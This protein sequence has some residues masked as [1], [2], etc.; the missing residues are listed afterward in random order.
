[1]RKHLRR[2]EGLTLDFGL[3][4]GGH[5]ASTALGDLETLLACLKPG[6]YLWLDD[7]EK[8]LPNIGVNLAGLTFARRWGN[9]LR[10][11]TRDSR[12]FMIHQKSF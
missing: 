6:G 3:V 2:A 8:N 1:V 11:Q 12:G 5:D 10:F 7:F 4:D 9:C